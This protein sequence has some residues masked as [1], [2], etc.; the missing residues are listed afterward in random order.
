MDSAVVARVAATAYAGVDAV[1]FPGMPP[2]HVFD[3]LYGSK[4]LFGLIPLRMFASYLQVCDEQRGFDRRS[5]T[6]EVQSL[7][8]ADACLKADPNADFYN[9]GEL[10]FRGQTR[11]FHVRRPIPNPA[12]RAPDG[13]ERLVLPGFWRAFVS[14]LPAR[15]VDVPLRPWFEDPELG[16]GIPEGVLDEIAALAHLGHRGVSGFY[17]RRGVADDQTELERARSRAGW[18]DQFLRLSPRDRLFR[19]LPL[20][21]QHYGIPTAGLDVTFELAT[22]CFF[23]VSEFA[24]DSRGR[25]RAER[26]SENS[27]PT[28]YCFAF[29]DPPV[30]HTRDLVQELPWFEDTPPVRPIRQECALLDTSTET[31]NVAAADIAATLKLARGFDLESL[32]SMRDLFP[33]REEDPFY[34]RLLHLKHTRPEEFQEVVEYA[35]I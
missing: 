33:S 16:R 13:L 7:A 21:Q 34:D 5:R 27:D 8:E 4:T 15:P 22:A 11:E 26:L 17:I 23:A 9:A 3:G 6:Y 12:M 10:A 18:P 20:I 25:L 32:P 31:V 24:E 29:H 2:A 19:Q 28:V 35:E 14:D 1:T 30:V